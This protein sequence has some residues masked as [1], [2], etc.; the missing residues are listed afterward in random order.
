MMAL[1]FVPAVLVTGGYPPV[2]L[3]VAGLAVAAPA[4]YPG[5]VVFRVAAAVGA[6]E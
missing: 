2:L 6:L 5:A 3:L 4:P 1:G